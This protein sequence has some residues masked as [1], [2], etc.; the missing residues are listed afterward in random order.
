MAK[1]EYISNP[2]DMVKPSARVLMVNL[3]AM[4][5]ML[6]VEIAS[7]TTTVGGFAAWWLLKLNGGSQLGATAG[8]LI[9]LFGAIT[10]IILSL[11]IVPATN[12]LYVASAQN[13]K[14]KLGEFLQAARPFIVRNIVLTILFVLAV[15]GGLILFVIPGLVFIAWFSMSGYAMVTED[16]GAV[17]SMK[18]S[19]ELVRGRV[20]E[21]W[22]LMS[23]ANAANV[24]PIFGSLISFGLSIVMLP[25]MAMRYLQLKDTAPADRPA[26]NWISY[27][28]IILAILGGSMAAR[29][30]TNNA[31]NINTN[32][33]NYTY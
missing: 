22:G 27:A 28:L 12:I 6:L 4:V 5:R 29:Y 21:T 16:L 10:L 1:S 23:L 14:R 3:D 32:P 30:N 26:V 13:Q 11:I 19:K 31:K 7:L 24:I 20:L 17:A 2:L 18:R 15:L 33:T 25:A 9:G 8:L